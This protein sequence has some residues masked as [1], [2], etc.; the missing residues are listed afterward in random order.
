MSFERE[1]RKTVK[2]INDGVD[3]L[4]HRVAAEGEKAKRD[5]AG[6]EMTAGEK[7]KSK[8]TE[9]K[10]EVIAEVDKAKRKVRDSV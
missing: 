1:I 6:S 9:T 3:E 7:A 10:H 5:L 2:N 4:G 8:V